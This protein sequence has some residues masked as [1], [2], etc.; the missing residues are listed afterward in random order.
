M[1]SGKAEDECRSEHHRR[2]PVVVALLLALVVAQAVQS[3]SAWAGRGGTPALNPGPVGGVYATTLV[4]G[5][6]FY[7]R[8]V[9]AQPGYVK[10]ADIYYVESFV[11]DP[12]GRRDNRLVSRQKNDW[13]G[14]ESMVVPTEKILLM[15]TIG[16]QSRLA[17]LIEQDKALPA[18]K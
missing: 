18:S 2:H 1:E 15:E 16:A 13:H 11:A 8:L 3:W 12:G 10:L 14:P 6:V 17:K 5:P 4:T 7:G 9:E